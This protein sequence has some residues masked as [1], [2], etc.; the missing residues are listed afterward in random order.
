MELLREGGLSAPAWAF[1]TA[2]FVALIG[3]IVEVVRTRRNTADVVPTMQEMVNDV[4]EMKER[5]DG[6]LYWHLTHR[7]SNNERLK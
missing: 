5:L 1:F 6:H 3:L 7:Q 4:R 2:I